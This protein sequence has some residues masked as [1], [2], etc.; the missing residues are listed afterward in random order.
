MTD[1][2]PQLAAI[3]DLPRTRYEQISFHRGTFSFF[4]QNDHDEKF[5][6]WVSR[7]VD[8][9]E[10]GRFELSGAAGA[11]ALYVAR[12]HKSHGH[13]EVTGEPLPWRD[14]VAWLVDTVEGSAA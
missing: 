10:V 1:L 2:P 5:S 4:I 14:A 7:L 12:T 3:D 11:D 6:V 9:H 8:W 13:P